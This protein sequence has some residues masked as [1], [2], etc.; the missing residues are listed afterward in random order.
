MSENEKDSVRL[1]HISDA[2]ATIERHLDGVSAEVFHSDELLVNLLARQLSIIGEALD[3]LSEAFK[4][5]N[6]DFPYRD[7]KDM[8]NFLIHEYFGV[9]E[10]VLWDT[11]KKNIPHLKK[12]LTEIQKMD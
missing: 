2:L 5:Q 3:C 4:Q 9:S 6:P 10:K 7:A 12:M 11:Y 8:R 1:Q